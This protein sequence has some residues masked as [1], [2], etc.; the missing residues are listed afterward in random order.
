[1]L[2]FG[3]GRLLHSIPL[4]LGVVVAAFLLIEAAPGDPV[5]AMVGDFPAS[6]AFIE[7]VT[8]KYQLDRPVHERLFAYVHNVVRG[9]L[10]ASLS[11]RRSVV[12]LISERLPNTVLLAVSG[13]GLAALLGIL[14]GVTAA[15]VRQPMLDTT[16]TALA[17]AAFAIPVF[18]LGQLLIILFSVK[19]GWLPSQGMRSL[20]A[21]AEGV[22][23]WLSV[24]S[25]LVLPIIAIAAREIGLIARITRAS[26]RDTMNRDYVTT[27]RA[28]GVPES[29]IV[30]RHA[31]KNAMLPVVTV[32][33]YHF[34]Y[35]LAG[36]IL[37]ETVFAW[38]GV[39]RLLYDAVTA[40]DNAV[41][42]GVFLL[43]GVLVVLANLITD[44]LYGLLDPR[45][46][47]ES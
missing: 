27:L 23:A 1:M 22:A 25:H 26:M 35:A 4:L 28:L 8:R 9:D 15:T 39:G 30:W 19:L 10:G 14:L 5:Q 33:G 45:I 31:L 20:R 7:E 42:V 3:L 21:P 37:V 40:R 36:T 2:A 12:S 24:A 6:P 41:V 43:A 17:L 32:I 18:W 11:N 47:T 44:L 29:R 13:L 46:R 38:P 34:G 16:I